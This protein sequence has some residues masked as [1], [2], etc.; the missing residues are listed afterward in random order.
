MYVVRPELVSSSWPEA[1]CPSLTVVPPA[2]AGV[3][4]LALAATA[5]RA[6]I[7]LTLIV[8]SRSLVAFVRRRNRARDV[9]GSVRKQ[10]GR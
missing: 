3:A 8:T 1:V 10:Y 4:K 9:D 2:S 7:V 5:S 6:T